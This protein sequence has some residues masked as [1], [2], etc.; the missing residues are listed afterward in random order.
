[1]LALLAFACVPV[2]AQAETVYDPE[3]PTLPEEEAKPKHHKATN[4]GSGGSSGD[5]EVS[6]SP[7][8]GAGAVSG[9]NGPGGGGE[10]AGGGDS[11]KGN[12]DN[13][14]QG[15]RGSGSESARTAVGDVAEN[16]PL[17]N[18]GNVESSDD[19]GSSSPLVPILIA[20]AALAAI[21][22][23]AV[24]IRQRRQRGPGGSVSP[25]AS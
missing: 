17:A 9:G 4:K 24:V 11:D 20:I 25:K 1:M 6:Q 14:G 5:A 2:V 3:S 13:S 12:P 18:A 21:S 23:G 10:S 8:G 19:G 22:I 16:Q 15:T 7:E